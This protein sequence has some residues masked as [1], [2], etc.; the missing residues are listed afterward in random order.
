ML[1][2]LDRSVNLLGM[3]ELVFSTLSQLTGCR[4]VTGSA[5]RVGKSGAPNLL[6]VSQKCKLASCPKPKKRLKTK[7]QESTLN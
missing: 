6:I 7:K 1:A 3:K 4:N 2:P 5:K